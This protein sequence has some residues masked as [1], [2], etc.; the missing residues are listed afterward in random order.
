MNFLKITK[1]ERKWWEIILWWE[2]RRIPYNLIMYFVGLLSFYIA[3]VT[4]PILYSFIGLLLN[5]IYTLGWIIEL[6]YAR[7]Q[8]DEDLK[9]KYPKYTFVAYLIF[10]I[11]FVV[12]L[13]VF[14]LVG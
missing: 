1:T 3:Y 14:L 10:S 7:R 13:A 9:L 12:G 5:A 8:N 2:L 6:L 4:I 11:F